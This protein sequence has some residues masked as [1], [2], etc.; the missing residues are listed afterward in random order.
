MTCVRQFQ[1]NMK[2]CM[3]D[4]VIRGGC[5]PEFLES[6]IAS[7]VSADSI[8]DHESMERKIAMRGREWSRHYPHD[9]WALLAAFL[10]H[11]TRDAIN[12]EIVIEELRDEPARRDYFRFVWLP[13]LAEQVQLM[14][15]PVGDPWENLRLFSEQVSLAWMTQQGNPP[16]I[17][18]PVPPPVAAKKTKEH[19]EESV[20]PG[21]RKVKVLRLFDLNRVN[22]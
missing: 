9:T 1:N 16:L 8:K 3:L 6:Y 12:I 2:E 21:D 15:C 22:A 10:L 5:K 14:K 18:T 17:R 4:I 20:E 13:Y 19:E 7:L 11:F